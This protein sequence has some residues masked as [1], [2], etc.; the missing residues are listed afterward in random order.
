MSDLHQN[1]P[2]D[3]IKYIRGQ[4][5][6]FRT[7][8]YIHS[9]A[10][11]EDTKIRRKQDKKES[12]GPKA[13]KVSKEKPRGQRNLSGSSR[14]PLKQ[15]KGSIVQPSNDYAQYAPVKKSQNRKPKPIVKST[16]LAPIKKDD[17]KDLKVFLR[18]PRSF[19][20][21]GKIL[22]SLSNNILKPEKKPGKKVTKKTF[23]TVLKFCQDTGTYVPVEEESE[24][25]ENKGKESTA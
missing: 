12:T 9:A 13:S 23:T 14:T 16:P 10:Q 19:F 1:V 4:E 8:P 6:D 11:R 3:C 5:C 20:Y 7:C 21:S 15:A 25:H 18:S 2:R 24:K 22:I 17:I